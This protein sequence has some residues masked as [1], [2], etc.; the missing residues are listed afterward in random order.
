MS[1]V[2]D[3]IYDVWSMNRIQLLD[4]VGVNWVSCKSHVVMLI[5]SKASLKKHLTGW[6]KCPLPLAT[7]EQPNGSM[8]MSLVLWYD[9]IPFYFRI[10][11]IS[12]LMLTYYDVWNQCNTSHKL[13]EPTRLC[14]LNAQFSLSLYC[15]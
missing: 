1:P 10:F 6:V 11:S 2:T 12:T 13:H 15:L 8:V 7:V 5:T 14:V 3:P 4:N 9:S